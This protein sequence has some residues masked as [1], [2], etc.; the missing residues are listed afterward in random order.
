VWFPSRV[1]EYCCNVRSDW[2]K[3]LTKGRKR[4]FAKELQHKNEPSTTDKQVSKTTTSASSA[5]KNTWLSR[6]MTGTRQSSPVEPLK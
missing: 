3:D 4:L 1:C 6:Y 2:P 5:Y